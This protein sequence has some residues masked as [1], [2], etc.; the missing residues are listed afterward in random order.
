MCEHLLK[1]FEEGILLL[2]LTSDMTRNHQR[3]H[4]RQPLV[5]VSFRIFQVVAS[6][7]VMASCYP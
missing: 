4:N 1:C 6:P 2:F 5:E 3:Y 7:K